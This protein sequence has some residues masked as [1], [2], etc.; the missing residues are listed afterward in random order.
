M[1]EWR[2]HQLILILIMNTQREGITKCFNFPLL[3]QRFMGQGSL[4]L[5]VLIT[6]HDFLF[7]WDFS[8]CAAHN[9]LCSL[10]FANPWHLSLFC[11]DRSSLCHNVPQVVQLF[12]RF[13]LIPTPQCHKHIQALM[14]QRHCIALHTAVQR[15]N[16]NNCTA[17][18]GSEDIY[19]RKSCCQ[20]SLARKAITAVGTLG[21]TMV[22]LG[23]K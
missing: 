4:L 20:G 15:L 10:L 19:Y 16:Y 18:I 13:S 11:C 12:F 7:C 22:F 14:L 23:Y 8:N 1:N 21:F 6:L 5:A 2:L 9:G 3:R 17:K